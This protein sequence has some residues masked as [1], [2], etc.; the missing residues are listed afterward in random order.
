VTSPV[1]PTIVKAQADRIAAL[2]TELNELK[3]KTPQAR[4][5][6][7]DPNIAKA[8]KPPLDG[9]SNTPPGSGLSTMARIERILTR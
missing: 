9:T 4:T 1:D 6:V 5:V 3:R 8:A 7:I 2:E